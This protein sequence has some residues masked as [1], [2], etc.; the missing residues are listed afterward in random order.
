MAKARAIVLYAV[1]SPLAADVEESCRRLDI[2]IAGAVK[3]VTCAHYLRD[4]SVV[5]ELADL[6]AALLRIPCIIPLFT[7]HNRNNA[8]REATTRGFTIAPASSTRLQSLR[9][10]LMWALKGTSMLV[11][12][13]GAAA[14]VAE[15]VIINRSS[16]IGHHAKIGLMASIGPA[17]VLAGQVR[18]GRGYVSAP[19]RSFCQKSK[20]A[21]G[22]L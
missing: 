20:L 12:S 19:V 9:R 11:R 18:I 6:D 4:A 22:A 21:P 16:S 5:R 10:P 13:Y 1:G 17:A 14:R 15:H 8:T 3:N 7:P 2:T